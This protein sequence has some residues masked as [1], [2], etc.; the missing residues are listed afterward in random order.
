MSRIRSRPP[1]FLRPRIVSA[2]EHTGPPVFDMEK[3]T[4]NT[5]GIYAEQKSKK[6]SE[7]LWRLVNCK[8]RPSSANKENY[9]HA[10]KYVV[11]EA[12]PLNKD[13]SKRALSSSP[14]NNLPKL[15]FQILAVRN[16]FYES[17]EKME[18]VLDCMEDL[19]KNVIVPEGFFSPLRT[20]GVSFA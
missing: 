9:P 11:K 17:L 12:F 3:V 5:K 18:R 10:A 1:L 16:S 7:I 6:T 19:R 2:K 15:S 20:R 14:S 8:Q 13:R 4:E